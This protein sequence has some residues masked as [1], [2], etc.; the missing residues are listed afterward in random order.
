VQE[1]ISLLVQYGLP[2]AIILVL[3]RRPLARMGTWNKLIS[4]LIVGFIV[5]VVTTDPRSGSVF[6]SVAHAFLGLDRDASAMTIR[7]FV[8]LQ[9]APLIAAVWLLLSSLTGRTPPKPEQ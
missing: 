5:S 2:S 7:V 3:I 6:K 4:V 1:A 9:A 8:A